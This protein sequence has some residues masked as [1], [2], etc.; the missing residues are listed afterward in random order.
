MSAFR[1]RGEVDEDMR[2][3]RS[4]K[5]FTLIELLIVVAIIGIIAAIAIPNLMNAMDRSKQKRSMADMKAMHN[6]IEQYAV[7]VNYYPVSTSLTPIASIGAS[8]LGLEPNYIRV[9]PTRDGW[10]GPYYYGSDAAGV[11]SDYTIVS[12]GKDKKP[13]PNSRGATGDFDCDIIFQNGV[14]TAAPEGAQN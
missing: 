2:K 6:A 5:G 7:D 10:G 1:P 8:A 12:Y 13:S 11:G 9:V 14:F 4:Q 3:T